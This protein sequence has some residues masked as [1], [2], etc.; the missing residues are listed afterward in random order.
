MIT[1]FIQYANK[2]NDYYERL[3]I[4][5][6]FIAKFIPYLDSIELI[7]FNLAERFIFN[8]QTAHCEVVWLLVL[9]FTN[10]V[11]PLTISKHLSLK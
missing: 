5:N 11:R 4:D 3:S 8:A 6:K 2:D 1:L 7:T 10:I 9:I